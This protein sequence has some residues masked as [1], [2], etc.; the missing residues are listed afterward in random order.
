MR[1]AMEISKLICGPFH[2]K[3]LQVAVAELVWAAI[4][5]YARHNVQDQRWLKAAPFGAIRKAFRHIVNRRGRP[6][7][8]L[9]LQIQHD[10]HV[11]PQCVR[12]AGDSGGA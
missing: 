2:G 3:T 10:L 4:G 5:K 6:L 11:S 1:K 12:T 8:R 9:G 7:I